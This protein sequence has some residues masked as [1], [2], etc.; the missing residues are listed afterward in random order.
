QV[1]VYDQQNSAPK[2]SVSLS[3]VLSGGLFK[4]SFTTLAGM[5]PGTITLTSD[6]TG[7]SGVTALSIFGGKGGN[8]FTVDQ[9]GSFAYPVNLSSGAGSD[10]V[11]VGTSQ[12]S[13]TIDGAGGTDVVTL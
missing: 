7:V 6:F 5:A 11:Y 13:L 3:S 4:T 12:A 8:T 1:T 2:G 10:T 9:L